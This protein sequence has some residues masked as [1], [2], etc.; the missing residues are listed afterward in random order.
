MRHAAE[1]VRPLLP[2]DVRDAAVTSSAGTRSRSTGRIRPSRCPRRRRTSPARRPRAAPARRRPHAGAA[3]PSGRCA[4]SSP[5]ATPPRRSRPPDGRGLRR[6]APLP[7]PDR[8]RR[9]PRRGDGAGRPP[10]PGAA[11]RR[12]A[13]RRGQRERR[14]RAP[15]QPVRR[16][17]RARAAQSAGT[18]RRAAPA[19]AFIPAW[20]PSR[21]RTGRA[22]RRCAGRRSAARSRTPWPATAS[23]RR[24]STCS[25][26]SVSPTASSRPRSSAPP[27]R[28]SPRA[29]RA[30]TGS[31]SGRRTG[32]SGSIVQY[33]TARVGAILV[34]VN[35]SYRQHE[36][37]FALAPVGRLAA[38]LRARLQGRRLPPARRGRDGARAARGGR[39]RRR[40][41][42]AARRAPT[43]VA[44]AALAAREAE[45][46]FDQ[47]INIQYTSGT[48]GFPKG[49]TLS[50]HNILNNGLFVGARAAAT[51]EHDRVCVPVPFYHCFGMVMGNLAAVTHGACVVIPSEAFDA[52]RGARGGR[53]GALHVALRRADDV[54]RDARPTRSFARVRRLDAAHRDHGRLAVPGR[55]DEARAVGACTCPR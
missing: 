50:H 54:H 27:A 52:A 15:A 12:D 55:G 35:P 46:H 21:T 51:R 41:E 36:L 1:E 16:V 6:R 10:A 49:A 25:R 42:R 23:A 3:S 19:C 18:A 31:G 4:S 24:S 53:G 20:T 33:A 22:P 13:R 44:P 28:C 43:G 11:R 7:L 14:A 45:L 40:L 2:A 8:R 17:R 30:A 5:T 29:S 47:P 39:A 32:S 48:T 9:I 37:S 38:R 26:A 34:N